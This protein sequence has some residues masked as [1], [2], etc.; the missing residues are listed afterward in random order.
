MSVVVYSHT[1]RNVLQ[2]MLNLG[3]G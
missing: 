1:K 2:H 3:L